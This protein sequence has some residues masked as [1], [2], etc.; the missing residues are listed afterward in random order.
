MISISNGKVIFYNSYQTKMK[1]FLFKL[2]TI[3]AFF[4]G[5][6]Q[7]L[8]GFGI[9]N[10]SICTPAFNCH[11]CPWATFACP[12]GVTSFQLSIAQIPL[13]P[14]SFMLLVGITVGRLICGF[15]CPA[16]LFQDCM[17]KIPS[18]KLQIP[19]WTR[20]IK[21]AVLLFLVLLIP[22][23][24]GVKYS[25]FIEITDLKIDNEKSPAVY[26]VKVENNSL[27]D[28]K[29]PELNFNFKDTSTEE[30]K[31]VKYIADGI[32]V[33]AGES[34]N[35]SVPAA[36]VSEKYSVAISSPQSAPSQE[37]PIPYLYFCRICPVGT[38]TAAIPSYLSEKSF[39]IL[40]SSVVR[41]VILLIFLIAFIFVSRFMCRIF[42]PFGAI[43]SLL[44]KFALFKM[45]YN[46]KLC[47]HCG[48]CNKV[49]PMGL[50]VTKEVG[51]GECIVCGDCLK[52]CPKKAILRT[53][54]FTK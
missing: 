46:D 21:Y 49:C 31:N 2:R 45:S 23:L 4:S 17:F 20:Y 52:V 24:M 44:S 42:C 1:S 14:I 9:K 22:Y 18:K 29:N 11:G 40:L 8:G 5:I 12:I 27:E 43:Y 26:T 51:T 30:V 16:G 32:T 3:T 19:K 54:I 37:I 34:K 36:V 47:V 48:V 13:Y 39:V 7:N 10:H 28:V 53:N 15:L 50:E 38:L 25:G 35:I 41:I 33:P 6:L